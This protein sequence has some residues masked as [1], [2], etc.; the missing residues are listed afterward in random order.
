[1]NQFVLYEQYDCY[2]ERTQVENVF[3][4]K[5][6]PTAYMIGLGVAGGCILLGIIVMVLAKR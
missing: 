6:L 3:I 1:M 5:Q 4:E 2:Y